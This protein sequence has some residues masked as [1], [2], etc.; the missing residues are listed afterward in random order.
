M[1]YITIYGLCK[2]QNG[3]KYFENLCPIQFK[4]KQKAFKTRQI[5][6]FYTF[7]PMEI[8]RSYNSKKYILT[9]ILSIYL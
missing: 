1:Y 4:L 3:S 2:V 6:I 9:N 7:Y 5:K 8:Y